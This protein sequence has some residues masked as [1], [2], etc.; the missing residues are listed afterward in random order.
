MNSKYKLS[1]FCE[2][3]RRPALP[4]SHF[5]TRWQAVVFRNWGMVAPERLALVLRCTVA[6][7]EEAARQMGLPAAHPSEIRRWTTLGYLSIIRQNWDLL[8][9]AALLELLGWT[10]E[11]LV[12]IL[13]EEDFLWHKLGFAKPLCPE[14][15][16]RP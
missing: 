16:Y 2:D 6:E 1:D 5:P 15:V 4:L 8:N 12:K 11:K 14:T 3:P 9:Y 13:R 7:V 10:R